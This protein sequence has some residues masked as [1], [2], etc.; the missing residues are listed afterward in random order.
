MVALWRNC[1]WHSL[2]HYIPLLVFQPC[3]RMGFNRSDTISCGY[4]LQLC[5]KYSVPCHFALQQMERT[6]TQMGPCCYLLAYCRK[7]FTNNTHCHARTWLLGLGA[8]HLRVDLRHSRNNIKFPQTEK[9]QQPRN[10]NLC[11]YGTLGVACH[12]TR[13]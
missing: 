13:Y 9:P 12:E 7:L 6:P 10:N 3:Q 4:A 8:V 5:S 11:G 2:W 1:A